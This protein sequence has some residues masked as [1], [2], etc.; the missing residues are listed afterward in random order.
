MPE[1]RTLYRIVLKYPPTVQDMLSYEALGKTTPDPDSEMLRLAKG[2][3]V[4]NTEQQA[5]RKAR[6]FPWKGNAYIAELRI[7]DDTHFVIERTT[8][9]QG[10]Y[11]IL[12]E[13]SAI[14]AFVS[15]VRHV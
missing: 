7:P 15:H 1:Y 2:L 6:G 5:R 13:P 12:A 11:T 8:H 4:Y 14:L 10:H 3:S 9:S